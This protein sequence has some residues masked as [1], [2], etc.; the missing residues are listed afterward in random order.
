MIEKWATILDQIVRHRSTG[1]FLRDDPA[2]ITRSL[3]EKSFLE[4]HVVAP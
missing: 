3:S 4:L 1:A 2:T